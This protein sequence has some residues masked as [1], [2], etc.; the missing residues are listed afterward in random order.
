MCISL[1]WAV[2]SYRRLYHL[3]KSV[4]YGPCDARPM[5]TYQLQ[6][7]T[8]FW[9]LV[10]NFTAHV[11][12]FALC[13]VNCCCFSPTVAWNM[14]QLLFIYISADLSVCVFTYKLWMDQDHIFNIS[15][16]ISSPSVL[17]HCWFDD[18]KAPC[19][20]RG[21]KNGPA[22]FPGRMSYKATKPGLVCL[23]YLSMLYYCTCIVVY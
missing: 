9:P 7:I 5:L 19:G 22:P 18:R 8:I 1:S 12:D 3:S 4:V 20:L 6:S 23:S 15:K 14:W 13:I 2:E 10:P 17:W 16:L 21:C 11:T